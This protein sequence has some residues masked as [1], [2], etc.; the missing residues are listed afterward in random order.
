MVMTNSKAAE[1]STFKSTLLTWVFL[2]SI[3]NDF[4][5]FLYSK[6]TGLTASVRS[7]V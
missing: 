3:Q 5:T 4:C 2:L 1:T 6:Y 7:I